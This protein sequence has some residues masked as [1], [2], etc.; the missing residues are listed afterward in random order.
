[1]R[2]RIGD[3]GE[4]SVGA[5]VVSGDGVGETK[6]TSL[7]LSNT[8]AAAS[9]HVG[10]GGSR[11]A[12][13]ERGVIFGDGVAGTRLASLLLS[14]TAAAASSHVGMGGSFVVDYYMSYLN[15]LLTI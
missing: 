5:V 10:I 12:G 9:S 2:L 7:L 1:M 6:L 8:A 14:N 3:G 11:F 13:D 15:T 4:V